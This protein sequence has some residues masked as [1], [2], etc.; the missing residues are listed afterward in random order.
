MHAGG[1]DDRR[2][3]LAGHGLG[4]AVGMALELRLKGSPARIFCELSDGEMQEGS[5][6]EG[7]DVGGPLRSTTSSR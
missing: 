3:G 1:R 2:L 6:W 4:Q 5:T 7:G